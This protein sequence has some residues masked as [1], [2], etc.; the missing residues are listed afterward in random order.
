M[1][2]LLVILVDAASEDAIS[3]LFAARA[4]KRE[5]GVAV[6]SG[7]ADDEAGRDWAR[8]HDLPFFRLPVDLEAFGR[9]LDQA[10][11]LLVDRRRGGDRREHPAVDR[12]VDG[13]LYFT[14]ESGHAWYVY[15][16]RAGERRAGYRAFVAAD[17]REM[18]TAL[19]DAEFAERDAAELT[20]QL[21]RAEAAGA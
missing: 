10:G 7:S 13:T 1:K 3:D 20:A 16:R 15:D 4:S 6:F 8:R 14:D 5:I 19:S 2:P 9:V 18:R 11:R 17:G 21:A 12:A